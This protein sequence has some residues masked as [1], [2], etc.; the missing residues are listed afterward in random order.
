MLLKDDTGCLLDGEIY[1]CLRRFLINHTINE[2]TN[3]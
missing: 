2:L 1:I 3:Y